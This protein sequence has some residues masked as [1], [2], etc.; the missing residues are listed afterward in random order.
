MATKADLSLI[1]GKFA[2]FSPA[3]IE[4]TLSMLVLVLFCG[5]LLVGWLNRGDDWV[6]PEYGLGYALGII[7]GSLM[8]LLLAYPLRKRAKKHLR[9]AGSIGFW[10]RFHMFLGLV[11][12]LA[13]LYHSRFSFGS[14]NSTIALSAMIIVAASGLVGRFLYSRVHR[15]FSNRKLE[16]Q[17]LRKEMDET[18][19][20][21]AQ[22]GV[23]REEISRH[24]QPFEDAAVKA[25]G[26][27]WSSVGAVL[28]L[29]VRTRAARRRLLK[30]LGSGRKRAHHRALAMADHFFE[31]ARRAAEF[32]FYDRLLRLWHLLHLPL[33]VLMIAGAILHI[34][35]V[36]MY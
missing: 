2:R 26:A 11:G 16:L 30:A 3:K 32:A 23:S 19:E 12:P 4:H 10:F 15:G 34:V 21:L 28:G 9:P 8:L 29:G 20:V 33:V 6:D 25:G 1:S 24:L 22:D 27:F 17:S 5:A 36:H 31:A 14:L 13:I 18:L 35:A 7:G